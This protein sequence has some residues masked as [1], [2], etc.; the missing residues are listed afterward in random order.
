[1]TYLLFLG[2]YKLK[3]NDL[4]REGFDVTKISDDVYYLDATGAYTLVTPDI[5]EKINNGI[6]RV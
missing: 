6:I 2:T 1:M 5:Y 4:Q 3:K